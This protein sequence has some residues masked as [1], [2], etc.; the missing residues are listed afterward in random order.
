MKL[1]LK[2]IGASEGKAQ[3]KVRIVESADDHFK[4]REGDIL[5]T[6]ITDP[7]MTVLMNRAAAIVCDIGGITSHPSIVSR[8]MG[9]PCVVNTK[10]ATKNLKDGMEVLVDGKLGEV[11]EI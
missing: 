3:G 5:V 11:Y 10:N 8:E 9:I 7:T 2:G 6:R 1:I 4:F